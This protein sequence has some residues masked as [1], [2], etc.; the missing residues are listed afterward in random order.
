MEEGIKLIDFETV[1]QM[2]QVHGTINR[3]CPWAHVVDWL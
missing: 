2:V 3:Q 1:D